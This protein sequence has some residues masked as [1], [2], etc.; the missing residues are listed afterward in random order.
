M[1]AATTVKP[2]LAPTALTYSAIVF[3]GWGA[4]VYLAGTISGSDDGSFGIRPQDVPQGIGPFV[5]I[6][7]F[8]PCP[9]RVI[10]HR[11]RRNPL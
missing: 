5:F 11:S 2:L 8:Q 7:T 6:E 3:E 4:L 9:A 10:K 1:A